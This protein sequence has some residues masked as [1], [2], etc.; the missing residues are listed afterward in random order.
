MMA[1]RQQPPG[2]SN[3]G[4]RE[5]GDVSVVRVVR[6]R[7]PASPQPRQGQECRLAAPLPAR[8]ETASPG[9]K[10]VGRWRRAERLRERARPHATVKY[11]P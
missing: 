6:Q 1:R 3:R 4:T 7:C 5:R 2:G 11:Q 8:S 10:V 9:A